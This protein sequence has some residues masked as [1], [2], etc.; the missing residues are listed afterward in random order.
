VKIYHYCVLRQLD[1]SRLQYSD[2]TVTGDFDFSNA[3]EYT[4]FRKMIA[5]KLDCPIGDFTLLSLT[6]I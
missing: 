6:E 1:Y 2:G 3:D 5:E 4:N